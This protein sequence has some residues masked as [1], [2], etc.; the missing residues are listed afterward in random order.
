MLAGIRS[1]RSS[2]RF[3]MMLAMNAALIL[4]MGVFVVLDYNREYGEHLHEQVATLEAEA[5]V[6]VAASQQFPD[7]AQFQNY[8]EK[9]CAQM[10]MSASPGHHMIVAGPDDE[11]QMRA[12]QRGTPEMEKAM[13]RAARQKNRTAQAPDYDVVVG[14]AAHGDRRV[15]VG[16]R[17]DNIEH[18]VR[19]QLISRL[20]SIVIVCAAIV[21]IVNIL[22]SRLVTRPI[23][24]LVSGVRAVKD[25]ALGYKIGQQ[26]A[27]EFQFLANEFNAMSSALYR[28]ETL[29]KSQMGRAAQVQRRLLPQL[30]SLRR[31]LDIHLIFRPAEEV[32]GD[33]Y[34]VLRLPDRR[35]LIAMADVS[36]H[37][38]PA[39][40][41]SAMLKLLLR[42]H[43][44][45]DASLSSMAK[46]IDSSLGKLLLPE[47]FVTLF[48]MEI[49]ETNQHVTYVNA[50]HE[51]GLL[52]GAHGRTEV[53]GT[54]SPCLG[55]NLFEGPEWREETV[56]FSPGDV[57]LI[58]TDGI[59]EAMN[60]AGQFYGRE[61]LVAFLKEHA[62]QAPRKMIEGIQA[63][64]DE[65]TEGA[66]QHD[67]ITMMA[68]GVRRTD[69]AGDPSN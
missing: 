50:G 46:D 17:L 68:I 21:L 15:I 23:G 14:E 22:L 38:V 44:K 51:R 28:A 60:E 16:E 32:G 3:R 47:D 8:L 27:E 56:P 59:P 69:A 5:R 65:F 4:I 33:F 40:M 26:P 24:A 41:I 49:D 64:V 20:T 13:L 48:L 35:W 30:D 62:G 55:M 18:L 12:H 39:A 11:I 37:G 54:T 19:S 58:W 67:D 42:T 25:G 9:Y 52:L 34:D 63:E 1:F 53:L 57:I 61:R 7:R 43:A 66:Q 36:G 29:R 6:V 31:D 45:G 2:L 10:K